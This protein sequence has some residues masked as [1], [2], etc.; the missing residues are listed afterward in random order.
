ML[1]VY[2]YKIPKPAHCIDFSFTTLDTLAEEAV[3]VHDHHSNV[4]IWFGYFEGWMLNP[5][6]EVLIRKLLRKFDCSLVTAFPLSLSAAW[7][8]EINIIYTDRSY[9]ASETHNHGG[10]VHNWG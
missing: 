9:G 8:N 4:H 3:A 7:K 6:E 2:T 5:R 1:D 10:S